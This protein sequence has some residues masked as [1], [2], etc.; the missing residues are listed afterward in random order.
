M[1]RRH[2]VFRKARLG[3]ERLELRIA[4]TILFG[5]R[6]R[7]YTKWGGQPPAAGPLAGRGAGGGRFQHLIH[8]TEAGRVH[9]PV[10]GQGDGAELMLQKIPR[11]RRGVPFRGEGGRGLGCLHPGP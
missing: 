1:A 5:Q 2:I 6:R 10:T 9:H 3:I 8:L 7:Q 11:G 4:P